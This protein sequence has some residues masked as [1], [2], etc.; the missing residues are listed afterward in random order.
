VRRVIRLR[1]LPLLLGLFAVSSLSAGDVPPLAPVSPLWIGSLRPG[2]LEFTEGQ[3]W[4]FSLSTAYGNSFSISHAVQ[5]AHL[6]LDGPGAPLSREAFDEAAQGSSAIHAVDIE[7]WRTDFEASFM[8]PSGYFGGGRIPVFRV[9]GT[10]LDSWA[11]EVHSWIG[12][13]NAGREYFPGEESLFALSS[14][15]VTVMDMED[16]GPRALS[17]DLWGGRQWRTQHGIR[18]RVWLAASVPISEME[19]YR[20][21]GT[22]LG[23]RWMAEHSF[24][25]MELSGGLGWTLQGGE[26]AGGAKAA[27]TFHAWLGLVLPLGHGV[28]AGL[29]LRSDGSVYRHA[30]PDR[31]GRDT[32]EFSVGLGIELSEKL[33]LQLALGEDFPGMGL[34]PDFSIQASLRWHDG[35][36]L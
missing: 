23:L 6:E 14:G 33:K 9:G 36:S 4:T 30:C 18:Q 34:P 2:G 27:D 16:Q 13:T 21:H 3:G 5:T 26:V 28:E 19:S 1:F 25:Y 32:G 15:A 20:H 10:P 35:W 8:A 22:G 7:T 12:V 17:L 11:E 24:R 29:L 31:A